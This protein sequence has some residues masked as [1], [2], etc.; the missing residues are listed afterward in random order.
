MIIDINDYL[1]RFVN[2]YLS[3]AEKNSINA[4]RSGKIINNIHNYVIDYLKYKKVREEYITPEKKCK[5]YFKT[6]KQDILVTKSQSKICF[7][8]EL[9]INV[10]SQMSSIQKNYDT[11]YERLIAEAVN[12]HE[13][14]PNLVCGYLYLLPTIGLDSKDL[15]K[16]II[17][18]REQYNL[19]QY[20]ESF[21]IISGRHSKEDAIYKYEAFGL[22][23]IDLD[24]NGNFKLVT[25][26]DY[27]V[28]IKRISKKFADEFR[29][30]FN[31]LSPLLFME[32]LIK[33][34]DHRKGLRNIL[35]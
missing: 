34:Y 13:E 22:I 7:E 12:L 9:S 25:D 24:S 5:G 33:E 8:P 31:E 20:I 19:E 21:L 23:L 26:L 15:S 16:G 1:R 28:A 4:I 27:L 32:R 14:Y 35:E 17:N 6:K 11:L 2:A 30:R 29:V 18:P 3:G 10:R